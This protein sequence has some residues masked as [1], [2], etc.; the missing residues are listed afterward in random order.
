MLQQE[1]IQSFKPPRWLTFSHRVAHDEISP[2]RQGVYGASVNH[3]LIRLQ[4]TVHDIT[5][6][7]WIVV[8][9]SAACLVMDTASFTVTA[10]FLNYRFP[11]KVSCLLLELMGFGLYVP[12]I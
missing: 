7:H 12:V 1:L 2:S 3:H 10:L 6:S 5:G 8:L 11:R 4:L 9:V